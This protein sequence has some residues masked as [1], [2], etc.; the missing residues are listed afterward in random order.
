LQL[1][2]SQPSDHFSEPPALA[3]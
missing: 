1:F 2:K 3:Q